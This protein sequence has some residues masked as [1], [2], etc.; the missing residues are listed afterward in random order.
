MQHSCPEQV[1]H[2]IGL[3]GVCA[4]IAVILCSN[5]VS[6]VHLISTTFTF[7][8]T[9]QHVVAMETNALPTHT[10]YGFHW[11]LSSYS[12]PTEEEICLPKEYIFLMERR[13]RQITNKCSCKVIER[14]ESRQCFI[15]AT[16]SIK[17]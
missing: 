9:I 6:V 14:N 11:G 17:V 10:Q 5:G 4:W 2:R 1:K 7:E 16:A 8:Q 12:G 15:H 13:R 3:E